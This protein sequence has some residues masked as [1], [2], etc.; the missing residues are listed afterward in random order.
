MKSKGALCAA[1][2][3]QLREAVKFFEKNATSGRFFEAREARKTHGDAHRYIRLTGVGD[4]CKSLGHADI[5]TF[6]ECE[7]AFE[8][9]EHEGKSL[10]DFE[11]IRQV[12]YS[13][14]PKGCFSSCFSNYAGYFC[15]SFN[16]GGSDSMGNNPA[17]NCYI[18]CKTTSK[19]AAPL[20][21]AAHK[22]VLEETLTLDGD[23]STVITDKTLFLTECS[24]SLAPV[25]CEDVKPGSIAVVIASPNPDALK[26]AV[27]SVK[28]A[29]LTIPSF[30]SFEA[31]DVS[32]ISVKKADAED[33]EEK[34]TTEKNERQRNVTAEPNQT[35][36][37][38]IGNNDTQRNVTAE[39][40]Q[41][42]EEQEK[43]EDEQE[44]GEAEAK[45]TKEKATSNKHEGGQESE[46][47]AAC[48]ER[49]QQLVSA[50]EA[51]YTLRQIEPLLQSHCEW[52]NVFDRRKECKAFVACVIKARPADQSGDAHA[53]D[54]CCHMAYADSRSQ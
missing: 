3:F 21:P 15:R 7:D 8:V 43:T 28:A 19:V 36:K 44:S 11:H 6:D 51:Q 4:T 13:F 42:G 41:T 32:N 45:K 25:T 23:Y 1:V 16:P 17:G 20:P 2:L 14:Q 48:R 26:M 47:T 34:E 40:S 30:G 31:K 33:T 18:L 10:H 35:E 24:T 22:E 52:D 9:L 5:E 29:G 49:L 27:T 53:Y 50:A 37:E 38:T 39:P 54:S 46:Y 12:D